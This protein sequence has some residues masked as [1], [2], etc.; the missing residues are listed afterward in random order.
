MKGR[1]EKVSATKTEKIEVGWEKVDKALLELDWS[2][3]SEAIKGLGDVT[4]KKLEKKYG[5]PLSLAFLPA[6]EVAD[7]SPA[8]MGRIRQYLFEKFV[9]EQ[10]IQAKQ[11]QYRNLPVLQL[12]TSL[13]KIINLRPGDLVLF[14]GP[15]AVGKTQICHHYAASVMLDYESGGYGGVAL[16]IDTENTFRLERVQDIY[17]SLI[18]HGFNGVFDEATVYKFTLR[19]PFDFEN[20]VYYE[21]AEV[22]RGAV[23]EGTPIRLIVVDSFIAPFREKFSGRG[24]LAPRQQ[25]MAHILGFLKDIALL[26]Q[27]PVVLTTQIVARPVPYGKQY[28]ASGGNTLL[29]NVTKIV[30]LEFAKGDIRKATLEKGGK[31]GSVYFRIGEGGVEDVKQNVVVKY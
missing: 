12:H 26:L 13:D 2:E 4:A 18:S 16:Y 29:H 1:V 3:L 11:L 8:I 28:A 22:F 15:P 31:P 25:M 23:E 14:Y 30:E 6:H 27:V 7:V 20:F 19:D 24:T 10:F 17:S 5:T 9:G 21:L